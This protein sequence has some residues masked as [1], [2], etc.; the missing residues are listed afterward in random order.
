M[1]VR[2]P[3]PLLDTDPDYPALTMANFLL[4]SGGNSRLWKR[5]REREGLSYDVR[6]GIDWSNLDR[7]SPWQASAIFAPQNRPRVEAAFQEEVARA[8]K[9][10]FTEQ[11][12]REG[13]ASLLNFRRL[14]R[15][16]DN[17]VAAALANNRYLGRTFE[18]AA[19]VDAAIAA[20]TPEQ[21]DAALRKYISPQQ[22][23]SVFAG[24]FKP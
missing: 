13:Q 4:G 10:G 8:L 14:S 5:I 1:L 17:A 11:E 21:V 12:L 20:L 2:L 16:Q 3:V 24:D 18:L 6:S 7:N 22:F 23:V 9:D 19:K 15:A